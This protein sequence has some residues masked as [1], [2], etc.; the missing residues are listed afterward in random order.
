MKKKVVSILLV[1]AMIGTMAAGCG[2]KKGS[3][4][5][6]DEELS[7]SVTT[8]FAGEDGNAGNYKEAVAA[9]EKE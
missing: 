2:S 5:G 7:L 6:K 1:T 8:T 3:E 4:E 9:F